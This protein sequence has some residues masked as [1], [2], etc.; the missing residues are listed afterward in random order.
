MDKTIKDKKFVCLGGGIGTVN[1]IKG[2]RKYTSNL[3]IVV[4][5]A[6]DGGSAG[7][8]RRAY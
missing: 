2:L 8:L 7:R 3:T 4:S 5:M 1:L 6:D